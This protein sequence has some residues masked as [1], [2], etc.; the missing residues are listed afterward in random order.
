MDW[1]QIIIIQGDFESCAYVSTKYNQTC[2]IQILKVFLVYF[3]LLIVIL[4]ENGSNFIFNKLLLFWCG[5]K[6]IDFE[7][8]NFPNQD[9]IPISENNNH[10]KLFFFKHLYLR[11]WKKQR[12][13]NLSDNYTQLKVKLHCRKLHLHIYRFS[14]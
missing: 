9:R 10:S 8:I 5:Q 12:Q 2:R 13:Q 11:I 7:Q 6:Q 3:Y 1:L 14:S 4:Y